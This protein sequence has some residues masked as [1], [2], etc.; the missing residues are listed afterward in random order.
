[1]PTIVIREARAADAGALADLST[2]LGYPADPSAMP[3]RL[4]RLSRDPNARAYA[5]AVGDR[6]IGLLTVHLRFTMN[7]EAPLAQITM[8][9]VDE[10]AR[11]TG[12]GRALVAAAEAWARERGCERIVVTTQLRRADAHA[13]YEKLEYRHT[14]R[15]YA[16][17]LTNE[18]L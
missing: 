12:A 10:A 13:F 5:A 3:G 17:S 7:H 11:G 1:M 16:R 4:E 15:R 6:V 14:G 8:L 9:V 18:E 2:Q